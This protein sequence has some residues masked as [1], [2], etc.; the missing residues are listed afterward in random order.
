MTLPT[1]RG[2]ISV[3]GSRT[4]LRGRLFLLVEVDLG[5]KGCRVDGYT[6]DGVW[7]SDNRGRRDTLVSFPWL[8][9]RTVWL[10][11]VVGKRTL[12]IVFQ[13][14]VAR[15]GRSCI[16]PRGCDCASPDTNPAYVS[17]ACP[18]HNERPAAVSGCPAR[19]HRNG[20][21]GPA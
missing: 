20:A 12:R 17:N 13:R 21:A 14:K 8:R 3:S 4:V 1:V 10:A 7:L 2:K 18:V 16:C 6:D 19:E 9:E 5:L 11:S 15:P